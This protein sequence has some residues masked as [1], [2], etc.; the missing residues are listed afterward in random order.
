MVNRIHFDVGG[1]I[2]KI[3]KTALENGPPSKLT[4]LYKSSSGPSDNGTC[5]EVDRPSDLFA[6]VFALYQTG[7]LHFP[8]SLCPGAFVNELEFWE[9]SPDVT[10]NC[11]LHR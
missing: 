1:Q 9:I 2:F 11:C 10:E 8:T 5:I 7:E 3:S 4:R 6:S